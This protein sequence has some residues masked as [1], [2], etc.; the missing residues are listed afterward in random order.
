MGIANI[1]DYLARVEE[2]VKKNVAGPNG[3]VLG[4]IE[5]EVNEREGYWERMYFVAWQN[6]NE[7]GTHRVSIDSKEQAALFYGTYQMAEDEAVADMIERS[8]KADLR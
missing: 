1:H 8:G 6:P 5:A 7:C 3:R 2:A 4:V